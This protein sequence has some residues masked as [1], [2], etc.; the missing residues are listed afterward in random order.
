MS[1]PPTISSWSCALPLTNTSSFAVWLNLILRY[2]FS[3]S[4]HPPTQTDTIKVL[5][6]YGDRDPVHG[7]FKGHGPHN[8]GVRTLHLMEPMFKKPSHARDVRQWDVTVRNVSTYRVTRINHMS[9]EASAVAWELFHSYLMSNCVA[10]G[11]LFTQ[12]RNR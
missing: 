3:F 1:N 11:T 4:S 10:K 9:C 6:A 5:W 8:R 7:D 2:L 12:Q